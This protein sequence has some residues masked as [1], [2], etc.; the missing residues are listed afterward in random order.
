LIRESIRIHDAI[1]AEMKYASK[2]FGDKL[3]FIDMEARNCFAPRLIT[4]STLKCYYRFNYYVARDKVLN[5]SLVN[6]E[7][8]RCSCKED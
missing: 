4:P 5:Y 6:K 3:E 8:P 2:K 7:C 1:K